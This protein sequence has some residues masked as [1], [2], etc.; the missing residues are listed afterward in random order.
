[1]SIFQLSGPLIHIGLSA[2][3]AIILRLN[4]PIAVF[5][6]I[7]PDLVDKPLAICG[8]GGGRYV[9]H[10]PLFLIVVTGL[11]FLWN[12]EYGFSALIGLMS[13]LILDISGFIPWFYPF[14]DYKFINRTFYVN[15]WIKYYM[16]FS[17]FGKELLVVC[18]LGIITLI[19][20]WIY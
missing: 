3:F 19:Y 8:I 6:S 5:C 18:S 4:I 10:T 15:Q 9:G 1:M 20:W 13:H 12:N 7:L 14:K 2:F 11:F 17:Q 16:N